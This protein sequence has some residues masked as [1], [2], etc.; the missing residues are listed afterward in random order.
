MCE[1]LSDVLATIASEL[2]GLCSTIRVCSVFNTIKME[3]M[4]KG[5]WLGIISKINDEIGEHTDIHGET[6][7]EII[8][9]LNRSTHQHG[10][11]Y[12]S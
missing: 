1:L 6:K 5:A 4:E 11:E 12:A 10:F 7:L 2:E 9:D 3:G 8:W